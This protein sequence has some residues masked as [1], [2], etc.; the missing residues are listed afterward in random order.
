[1][2][3]IIV[4]M[5]WA[6]VPPEPPIDIQIDLGPDVE[7]MTYKGGFSQ[8]SSAIAADAA[9]SVANPTGTTVV[10]CTDTEYLETRLNYEVEGSAEGPMKT[11]GDSIRL[12]VSGAG[13]SGSVR[14]VIGSRPSAVKNVKVEMIVNAP[15]RARLTVTSSDWVQ[16]LGCD[17]YVNATAGRNG[18]YVDGNLTGFAVTATQGDV[19]VVV[20]NPKPISVASSAKAPKGSVSVVMPLSQNLKFDARAPTVNVAHTVMGTVTGAQATGTVGSGGPPMTLTASGAVDVQTP[21]VTP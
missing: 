9:V 13:A 6:D 17:G 15:K 19:K 3:A 12:S 7:M 1:M 21:P 20:T 4:A 16:V 14:A 2:W 10:R 5:A 11:Y 8:R 18:A